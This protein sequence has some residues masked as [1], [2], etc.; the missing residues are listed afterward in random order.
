[1]EWLAHAP[2]RAFLVIFL[3]SFATGLALLPFVPPI[4][5]V[6]HTRWEVEAVAVSLA[7]HGTF[8][9]PYALP[10]GPTAHM[11]PAYP[12]FLSLLYRVLGLTPT[13]GYVAWLLRV[14]ASSVMLAML[15]WLSR[16]LGTGTEA[17]IIGGMAAAVVPKWPSQVEAPAAIALG[18]LL[19]GFVARWS[20]DRATAAGSLL[21]GLAWGVAFHLTPSLLPV[22][23][24]CMAFELWWSRD[25]RK[26]AWSIAIAAGV[27]LACLPWAWR[28]H[29]AFG[30]LIFIRSNAGLE[31]RMGNHDGAVADVDA[32]DVREGLAQRHPRTNLAEAR[33]VQELGEIEYMR[34][35]G[36]EAREWIWHHPGTYLGLVAGRAACFWFGSPF[37]VPRMLAGAVLTLL[38]LFGA[39]RVLPTRSVPQR[40]AFLIPLATYPLVYYL[41]VFTPRY[42]QPLNGLL[43]ILAGAGVWRSLE[44]P[45]GS[46]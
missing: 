24:G 4:A 42:A 19:A 33:L 32:I 34:R 7:Q 20:R 43:L 39:L 27:V 14:G 9:D 8:A 45:P 1:M 35:A 2:W 10:T 21:M 18:L 3:V 16:R 40:A 12:L 26:W 23:V 38:A 13:A 6:P 44:R 17:G 37:D 25:P 28:N 22:L 46:G 36:R 41:I 15:P 31:L 29:A 11:P 5:L 30:E